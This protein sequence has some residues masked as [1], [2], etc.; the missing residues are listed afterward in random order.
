MAVAA[1]HPEPSLSIGE[2]AR[3]AG[4]QPSTIRYYEREGLLPLPQRLSGRRRYEPEVLELLRVI[5]VSKAAGFTLAEIQ[6]LMHGFD[7]ATPPSERWRTLAEGKLREVESVIERAEG[8]RAL[9]RRG[10][11]CGCLTLADCELVRPP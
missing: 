10:I 8:M 7:P 4:V 11:E 2:V 9:L 1:P 3:R 5:E 6:E